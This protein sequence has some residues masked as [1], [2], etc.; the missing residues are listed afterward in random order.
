MEGGYEG[1]LLEEGVMWRG[2]EGGESG[3]ILFG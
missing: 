3:I 2:S 1:L